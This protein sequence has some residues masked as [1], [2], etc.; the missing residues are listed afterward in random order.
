[1]N[2]FFLRI[3]SFWRILPTLTFVVFVSPLVIVLLSLTGDYSDNW[4]HLYNFVLGD[5]ITN[6]ILL[7]L[8]VG[9]I[10]L[11]IGTSSAWIITKYD[12]FGRRILEWA[13]ILPLAIPPYILAYTF[14][15]LF[16]D[17]GSANEFIRWIFNLDSSFVFFPNVR[18]IFGAIIV[19]AFTL[20]PY[21]YLISRAAFLNQS[22]TL[23]DAGRILGLGGYR[24]FINLGL[25]MIRPAV[26]AGLMLVI[27]ETLSDFGAVDHFAIQTFT[28]GIFRTWYG[29][30]DLHTA[31][32]LASLLLLF[33]I[34]F[35]VLERSSRMNAAYNSPV[36]N[37]N[38]SS[39]EKLN[40]SKS[41][42]CFIGCFIPIFIGFILPIIEL[43]RW[44]FA[45]N[46]GF[47][48]ESFF[49]QAK[50]TILIAL[51][52]S[53]VCTVI[54]FT[55][56]FSVRHTNVIFLKRIN[57][58]LSVGYGVPGLILA[59]GIVQ[60]FTYL[61]K[62]I[63][64]GFDFVLTGSLFGLLLAY[65][66]KSYALSNSTIESGF[67]RLS[68]R[69]DDSARVLKSSGWNLLLRVHFPLMKTSLLT[70]ILLVMSEVVKELPATL[71]LRPFNFDTLAVST[72]IYAAEER[73]FEAAS[74]AIAIVVI[75]LIPIIILTRMIK[76]SKD[77][78]YLK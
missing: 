11:I 76:D 49:I 60:M 73:M 70:S 61:D 7:V 37:A 35:L 71:I 6:S 43:S 5:Y 54:A 72:Y 25:P 23:T 58:F 52:A 26:I 62:G 68:N 9:L 3:F 13:L 42:L 27:M 29:M 15:G 63:F 48:N 50:N 34:V 21:I 33:I 75:G 32:Q 41:F 16:D 55:I 10:S 18:N 38:S 22:K 65:L 12:F 56:N 46:T 57:P 1:M 51:M 69:L 45:Y 36:S 39:S 44:A 66:I 40:G 14:T 64:I 31:M 19:F 4:T 17:Y 28:T 53:I 8:G 78:P 77:T 2:Y 24:I 59:V 30:Y 20:Y 74:P 67:E 47:F